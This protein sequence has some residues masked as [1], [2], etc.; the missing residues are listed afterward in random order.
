MPVTAEQNPGLLTA[1][2]KDPPGAMAGF[3]AAGRFLV[4]AG[5]A[6]AEV[7]FALLVDLEALSTA[8]PL[9]AHISHS[10]TVADG[11]VRHLTRRQ[12]Q[13]H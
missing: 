4:F 9:A 5:S 10:E 12:R 6:G 3:V 13:P 1:P 2:E 7:V 11:H 8:K